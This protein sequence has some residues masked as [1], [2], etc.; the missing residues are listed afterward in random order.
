MHNFIKIP[1]ANP[2]TQSNIQISTSKIEK[3][4][5]ESTGFSTSKR[6]DFARTT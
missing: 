2:I 3:L 1:M 4:S 6:S 5:T